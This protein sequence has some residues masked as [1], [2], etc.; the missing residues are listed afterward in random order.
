[1]ATPCKTLDLGGSTF[2]TLSKV[3]SLHFV[4][5]MGLY[6][7]GKEWEKSHSKKQQ[8]MSF[9]SHSQLSLSYK[10]LLKS[11]LSRT[12]QIS[13]CTSHMACS[14]GQQ[15][16]AKSRKPLLHRFF[17]KLSRTTLTLNPT[18]IQG[19]DWTELQSNLTR[20]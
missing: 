4:C 15:S 18:K 5:N 9:A 8:A 16:R 7:V 3:S 1:M 12:L 11:S 10:S 20:N 13:A 6:S 19:N 17:T 2:H 14:M